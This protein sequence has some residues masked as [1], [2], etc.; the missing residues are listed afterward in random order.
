ML[1]TIAEVLRFVDDVDAASRW[2]AELFGTTVRW[3]NPQFAKVAM[4]GG[5]GL[6]FHP[7]DAK[8]PGGIGGTTVYWEVDDI[9]AAVAW[10]KGKG[11]KLHRGPVVTDLGAG[12]AMLVDPWGCT[13]GLN[14]SS[15]RS[16]AAASGRAAWGHAQDFV[17]AGQAGGD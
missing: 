15:A 17:D 14:R 4:P 11:A 8:C 5:V 9:D 12:A 10:L 13:I 3:E 2:Y 7:A 6:G 1:K 16:R